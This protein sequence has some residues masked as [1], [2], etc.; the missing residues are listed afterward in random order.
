MNKK[1]IAKLRILASCVVAP[2]L[3]C[4][5]TNVYVPLLNF[6]APS[7]KPNFSFFKGLLA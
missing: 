2:H 5:H 6:T 3:R 7:L 1:P 4:S